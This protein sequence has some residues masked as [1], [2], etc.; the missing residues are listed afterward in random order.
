MQRCLAY[1]DIQSYQVFNQLNDSVD[2]LRSG[3]KTIE[4]YFFGL[5]SGSFD[6]T[7]LFDRIC[8]RSRSF[9]ERNG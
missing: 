3:V 1:I 7:T 9:P 8:Q 5:V 2:F 4:K 6:F